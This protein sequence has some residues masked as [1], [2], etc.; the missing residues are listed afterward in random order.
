MSAHSSMISITACEE[1][2]GGMGILVSHHRLASNL[3][4]RHTLSI[5]GVRSDV[6]EC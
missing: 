5:G 4:N 3:A 6:A 2:F 1:S